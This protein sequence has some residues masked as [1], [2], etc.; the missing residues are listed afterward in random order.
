MKL[1]LG[2]KSEGRKKVLE[3]AGYSFS[4]MSS[5]IDEKAIRSDDFTLLPL[6]L[7]REKAKVLLKKINEPAILITSDQ[8]VVCNGKL[9]E[10]PATLLEA[11]SYLESYNH[12]WAQT[13]TAI[14]VTNTIT[15]KQKEIVDTAHIYFKHIP[16]TVIN[17]LV[18]EGNVLQAA[19]AIIA[20][21][22]LLK[23]YIQ[24]I[25]GDRTSVTGLALK[26]TK[27]LIDEVV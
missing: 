27:K 10:K 20:E 3:D 17:K 24:R 12:F 7:A 11:K 26:L 16:K 18:D 8:V 1:I 15:G 23:P 22:P 6:L 14:V 21:H 25:D 13:N 2:S 4:V 5:D 9:R 19:G